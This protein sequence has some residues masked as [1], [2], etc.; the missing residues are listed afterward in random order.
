MKTMNTVDAMY[1][2]VADIKVRQ[3]LIEK[4]R[5][6]VH[7]EIVRKIERAQFGKRNISQK[8]YLVDWKVKSIQRLQPFKV[9]DD[10]NVID[11]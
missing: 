4:Q 7:N 3:V 2:V 11:G 10:L 1:L 8:G 9:F 6:Y 5:R